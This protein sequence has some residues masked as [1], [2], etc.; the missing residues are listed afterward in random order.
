MRTFLWLFSMSIAMVWPFYLVAIAV[1]GRVWWHRRQPG[2]QREGPPLLVLWCVLLAPFALT[3]W[4]A[5][6]YG[7]ERGAG[8]GAFGWASGILTGLAVAVLVAAGWALWRWRSNW[9]VAA[10]CVGTCIGAT[11]LAWFVGAMAIVDDWM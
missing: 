10:L 2:G 6:T 7:A 4:A 9:P 11:A 1:V 3:A 8:P 5:L